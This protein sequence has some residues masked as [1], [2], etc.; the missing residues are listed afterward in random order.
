MKTI[1]RLPRGHRRLDR[2]RRPRPPVR[3]RS[4]RSAAATRRSPAPSWR[5]RGSTC[6]ASCSTAA[7]SRPGRYKGRDVTILDV[8]EARRR[9]RRRQDDRRGA[10]RARGGRLAPAPA[11]A[12]ASSPPTRWR[13]RSRCSASRPMGSAMVPAPRTRR[14]PT[15]PASAASSIM[16]VLARGQR[17]RDIITREESLENAIAAIATSGGSTNGVLHLLARRPRGRRRARHRRLRPHLPQRTPLLCDLKPGGRYVATDLYDAGGVAASSPSACSRP[18]SCTRTRRPSPAARSA[19]TPREAAETDGP[20]GRAPARRAA[21]ADRRPRD[22]ARQPRAR[23]LRRQARR[24]RARPP[25]GPGARVRVRGGRDG[26]RHGRRDRA[27]ATSSSS[28]TRARAGG[29]GMREMLAVTAAL[30]GRGA[31]RGGRAADRRP[32]LRRHARLHGRPRRARGGRAAARSP[33]SATATT[34]TIDVDAPPHG[35]RRSPTRRS[36]RASPP[37]R[38]RRPTYGTGVLAKYAK[39]VVERLRGRDHAL[40]RPR[41]SDSG[42]GHRPARNSEQQRVE[43]VGRSTSARGR[44][45]RT[46]PRARSARSGARSADASPRARACRSRPTRSAS[47]SRS[48][49]AG[50]GS[51]SRQRLERRHEAG[52]AGARHQLVG[53]RRREPLR[54]AHDAAA[55]RA[56]RSR[57]RRAI[58]ASSRRQPRRAP[59]ATIAR[60]RQ[61]R[62][63][64]GISLDRQPGGATRARAARPAVGKVS[65]SSAADEPAHRVADDGDAARRPSVVAAARR[66]SARSPGSRSARA[67]SPSRRSPGR[68]SAMHAVGAHEAPGCSPA[69]SASSP[70]QPVDED[71]RRA[72][73]P[74]VSTTLT[75]RPSTQLQRPLQ[76][77]A[78][79]RPS[80]SRRRRPRTWRRAGPQQAVA[81][82]RGLLTRRRPASDYRINGLCGSPSTSTPRCTT[83][84]TS[85]PRPPSAAS[86]STLPYERAAHLGIT[87]LR[88]RAGH[89]LRRRDPPRRRTCSP[90]SP[91]RARSR[92][93]A[94]W[95]EA[96]PLHPHHQ[97][98]RAPTPT[99]RPRAWLERIGLPLRRALLLL[100]Q[101]RALPRR[102]ASTLLIDDSPDN[103]AA[104][105]RRRHR[106]GDA[107]APVEPRD[108]RDRGRHLRRRLARAGDAAALDAAC[109]SG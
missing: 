1:A 37:T 30:V 104:R 41:R 13:W 84:G 85:S 17:P 55:A 87:H 99:T 46:R 12:A 107:A 74:P 44:C 70:L 86:A 31:R 15:S 68:S 24:P 66:R 9:A 21:Q 69:S 20:G 100:R 51:R 101:G 79:R 94:R 80:R 83:T 6:P 39:L 7:R 49:P 75:A 42:V 90:P 47:G 10:R 106:R 108:L 35:R 23:G 8:F 27:P 50:R 26:R 3:R 11:P 91:T 5:S 96:G 81:H 25:R 48:R 97:P 52:L 73:A 105:A 36:P 45:R 92:P 103:L 54:V 34:I 95:H 32:L 61:Q 67:A 76:R 109:W 63:A 56:R 22:P 72:A 14:R 29:P 43:A 2:A 77:R 89:G 38:P 4:S 78:S 71:E 57:G 64:P 82:R 62:H 16:D 60:R 102:S 40:V 65:A 18:G 93:S 98:P 59:A 88:P 19:S 58:A 33:R 28:A 53:Q